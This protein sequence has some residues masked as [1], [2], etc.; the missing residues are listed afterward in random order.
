MAVLNHGNLAETG[1]VEEVFTN[2]KTSAA[3]VLI[4]NDEEQENF[5]GEV[6]ENY[7]G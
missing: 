6:Y 2:P 5:S 1:T 3:K 4:I 7:V